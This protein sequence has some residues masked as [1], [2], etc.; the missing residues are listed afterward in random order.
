MAPQGCASTFTK[1]VTSLAVM[2]QLA[3]HFNLN[4]GEGCEYFD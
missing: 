1:R 3:G 2:K 4:T